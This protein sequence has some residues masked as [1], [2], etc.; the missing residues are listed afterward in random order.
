MLEELGFKPWE[1]L[2]KG[3]GERK[4]GVKNYSNLFLLISSV[5][6]TLVG[7]ALDVPATH[8]V[9]S[10]LFVGPK[11]WGKMIEPDG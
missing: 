8:R 10:C 3:G 7:T 1:E 9:P 4:L 5:V 2:K 6:T 11:Q